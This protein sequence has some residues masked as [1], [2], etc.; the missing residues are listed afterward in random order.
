MNLNLNILYDELSQK[1]HCR[2]FGNESSKLNLERPLL[3]D[4]DCQLEDHSFYI[5]RSDILPKRILLQNVSL[6]SIGKR[7]CTEWLSQGLSVLQ[8]TDPVSTTAVF[9]EVYK[10]YNK[11][12]AWDLQLRDELEKVTEFSINHMLA[13][14]TRF[15]KRSIQIVDQKL[16]IIFQSVYEDNHTKSSLPVITE[17]EIPCSITLEYSEKMKKISNAERKITTPYLSSLLSEDN[18]FYCNNLYIYGHFTGCISICSGSQ[19]FRDSDYPLFDHFFEY[20]KNGFFKHLQN[21]SQKESPN[22]DVLRKLFRQQPLSAEEKAIFILE[23]EQKWLC[24]HAKPRPHTQA[25][26]PDYMCAI[27]NDFFPNKIFSMIHHDKIIG[28]LKVTAPKHFHSDEML[29]AFEDILGKM[30]Y[31]GS[32]SNSFSMPEQAYEYNIQACYVIDQC[33][34]Y[35]SSSSID[36]FDKHILQYMLNECTGG[37]SEQSLYTDSLLSVIQYDKQKNTD[38]LHTLEVYLKNEMSISKTAADL[39]LHRNSLLKRLDKLKQLLNSD[40]EDPE[41]K[42]YYRICLAMHKSH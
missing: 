6:I 36:F 28:L 1:Y 23:D 41:E 22:M 18:M 32:L 30:D 5:A 16:Q 27:L 26:P 21:S 17:I 10:I 37:L 2:L 14:G 7:V 11:F 42:L 33:F 9:N 24:F 29:L 15:F 20:I 40:L 3:Y 13:I 31:I 19:K 35:D 39:Y 34:S 8:V 38:Y 25:L 12:E 4:S